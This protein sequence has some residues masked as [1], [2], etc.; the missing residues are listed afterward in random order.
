MPQLITDDI[1]GQYEKFLFY[2]PPGSGKTFA[3]L[4]GPPPTYSIVFGGAN[5]LKT[6]RSID[7]RNKYPELEGQLY[8]DA[9]EEELGERG[10]FVSATAY[11]KAGD[12]ISDALEAEERG[13]FEFNTLVIDSATGLRRFA[14]NKAMEVNYE[15]SKKKSDTALQRFRDANIIIPGDNDYMSEMSLTMQLMEWVFNL[16]KNVIVVTHQHIAKKFNRGTRE[17]II[18]AINPLFTGNHREFI[19]AIFD[20]VWFFQPVFSGKSCIG[21]AQTV[22][23]DTRYAKTRLGGVL[24]QKLRDVN[25]RSVIERFRGAEPKLGK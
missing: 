9:V 1:I 16:D 18:S 20:N 3:S 6:A 21:E 11:D 15:R 2:G 22:G 10:H 19:P 8:F 23:D 4:T 12:L 5:E 13:D 24:P 7:F 14:M 25:V 17:N